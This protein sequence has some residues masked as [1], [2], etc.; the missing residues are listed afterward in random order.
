MVITWMQ[1]D[2]D[3]DGE[4]PAEDAKDTPKESPD[5]ALAQAQ[6]AAAAAAARRLN[7]SAAA[8]EHVFIAA[9]R[10]AAEFVKVRHIP[11]RTVSIPR[12][13]PGSLAPGRSPMHDQPV[14]S[15]PR[16]I[17]LDNEPLAWLLILKEYSS[18]CSCVFTL[19]Q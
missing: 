11:C 3:R 13:R 18:S 5:A 14:A 8:A 10:R 15:V 7:T 4:A 2:K 6:A 12:A 16:S 1:K 9:M 19:T 17:L